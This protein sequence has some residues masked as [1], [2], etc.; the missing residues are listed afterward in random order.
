MKEILNKYPLSHVNNSREIVRKE[1][2]K[3]KN[4]PSSMQAQ[5]LES[6]FGIVCD[7]SDADAG[8]DPYPNNKE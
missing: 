2:L 6:K 8:N 4:F 5:K 7:W 1:L 3:M